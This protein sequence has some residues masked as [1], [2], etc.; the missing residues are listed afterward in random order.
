MSAISRIQLADGL[1]IPRILH[2]LWQIADMEKDG[3]LVDRAAA[4]EAMAAYADAG[5]D[6]FDMADHYG[7]AEDIAGTFLARLDRPES[8]TCLTKWCPEP[9]YLS[10]EEIR[11]GLE[12]S[13]ERMGQTTIDLMQFHWW[14]YPHPAY[15]DCLAEMAAMKEVGAFKA[16][17]L[18]NTDTDHLALIL[19]E[20][21]P[22][23]TN[24]VC[25]SLLDRRASGRMAALCVEK[26]VKLLC[27]G[28]LA[29]GYLTDRWLD[30]PEPPAPTDWSG[31][32]YR[33]FIDAAGGWDALQR[34]LRAARIVA[35]R[36]NCSI[37]TVATRWVL[38]QPAVGAV[39]VGA[40]L[41][42]SA[43][44]EDTKQIF[45]IT[46]SE[47]DR[48]DLSAAL[49]T[50]TPIP[51]DCGDEYRK[52]P[53]LTASGDLSHHLAALPPVFPT[54]E[55]APGRRIVDSGS[56]WEEICGFSRAMRVGD[57]ILVSGTT[58]THSDGRAI[59][60]NNPELQAVYVMDKIQA[61]I[62]A[63]GGSM[64]DVVRTRVF[65]DNEADWEP[66]SY[67]HGRVFGQIR[68]SNTLFEIGRLID[69]YAVE[70]EAEAI[71]LD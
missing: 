71:V 44:L 19:E 62:E 14:H 50:L 11:A 60:S 37:A 45:E 61:A 57:R 64:N 25:Q 68:P 51:G 42:K 47:A 59:A 34:V 5:F 46:L 30:Q 67:A 15:L 36:H 55:I 20:G 17:G 70:I 31:M 29:G 66:I 23:A 22:I 16:I 43:H 27:Y 6:G 26:G 58:A 40:R 18:T 41:G 49:D 28:T 48:A 13:F 54:R 21:I 65:L 39:I 8:A 52:P 38:D 1:T 4:A 32:K 33:R 12:L 10:K 3:T 24:Q 35:D 56:I 69:G 2:G 9:G 63:L 53:F 7:S